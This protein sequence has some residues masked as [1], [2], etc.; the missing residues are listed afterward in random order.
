M[1][2]LDSSLL[3]VIAAL[4]SQRHT[5][6]L[7]SLSLPSIYTSSLSLYFFIAL[8]LHVSSLKLQESK[9]HIRQRERGDAEREMGCDCT[10]TLVM[11]AVQFGFAGLNILSKLA[12]DSGMSAY[13]MIAYRQII[14][15]LFLTP[16]AYF[17]E[18]CTYRFCT[19]VVNFW[20]QYCLIH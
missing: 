14:G 12:L 20:H 11:V 15:S 8:L 4:F 1:T 10:P 3:S 2:L 5:S 18:R 6:F 17:L 16:V 19:T 13:V 9:V 7:L